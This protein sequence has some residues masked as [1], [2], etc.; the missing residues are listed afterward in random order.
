MPINAAVMARVAHR[1]FSG[2]HS[3]EIPLHKNRKLMAVDSFLASRLST[4]VIAPSKNMRDI[5]VRELKVPARKVH[6]IPHGIDLDEWSPEKFVD[7][8]LRREYGVAAE[9]GV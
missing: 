7:R 8:T 4:D 2:H 5:F 9:T 6:V 1:I 3:H